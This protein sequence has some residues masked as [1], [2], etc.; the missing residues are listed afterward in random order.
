MLNDVQFLNDVK[1]LADVRKLNNVLPLNNVQG[2]RDV[3]PVS[4]VNSYTTP[5]VINMRPEK[6][7]SLLDVLLS[8]TQRDELLD[9]SNY[10]YNL[11][12][13]PVVNLLAGAAY[14][15][16]D[17]FI[18]PVVDNGLTNTQSYKEIGLNTLIELS[19]DLDIFSNLIKSQSSL[20]GGEF[21][22][23]RTF[24]D[25][26]GYSGER[27]V[28]NY[29]T[30]NFLSDVF[31]ETI[32]DPLTIAE[33]GAGAL[34]G[35]GR[36][37]AEA[38]VKTAVK[39]TSKEITEQAAR[40]IAEGT[41][42]SVAQYGDDVTYQTILKN[43]NRRTT[44]ELS[45]NVLKNATQSAVTTA[46]K[47]NGYRLF[48]SASMLKSGVEKFDSTLTNVIRYT[49]PAGLPA[50]LLH[51]GAKKLG[52]AIKNTIINS[53]NNVD[54]RIAFVKDAKYR[55][56]VG[57]EVYK[58]AALQQTL[59]KNEQI[60]FSYLGIDPTTF[61][62]DY[63]DFL[64][65]NNIDLSNADFKVFDYESNSALN[66]NSI[67]YRFLEY[68]LDKHI[69]TNGLDIA[70]INLL[71][72]KFSDGYWELVSLVPERFIKL[73]IAP[74]Q[75]Y[76]V[77][78]ELQSADAKSI[79]NSLENY[80]KTHADNLVSTYDYID[81]ELLKG[82]GLEN[83]EKYLTN[84]LSTRMLNKED[85]IKLS[86]LLESLGLSTDNFKEIK[87][88]LNSN[89]TDTEKNKALKDLIA[90]TNKNANI[91]TEKDYDKLYK[92]AKIRVDKNNRKQINKL[93][94]TNLTEAEY[95]PFKNMKQAIKSLKNNQEIEHALTYIEY[96]LKSQDFVDLETFVKESDLLLKNFDL[97][98]LEG[99]DLM[100]IAA[101][102]NI[103]QYV[104]K[105]KE[106]IEETDT[107]FNDLKTNPIKASSEIIDWYNNL[108]TVRKQLDRLRFATIKTGY[109]PAVQM[110]K[111][112]NKILDAIDVLLSDEFVEPACLY[113]N[114][115][116]NM[117]HKQLSKLGMFTQINQHVHMESDPV[118]RELLVQ[119]SNPKSILRTKT[120]PQFINV[121]QNSGLYE[122]ANNVYKVLSQ[123]DT[124]TH[125]NEL[126]NTKLPTTFKLETSTNDE[127]VHIVFDSIINHKQYSVS[128]ML[129]SKQIT[130]LTDP[131]QKELFDKIKISKVLNDDYL[132]PVSSTPYDRVLNEINSRIDKTALINKNFNAAEIAEIKSHCKNLLDVYLNKQKSIL[133][134]VP[135]MTLASLYSKDTIDMLDL[136][137][138]MRYSIGENPNVTA[139]ELN[140]FE[141]FQQ[142][143]KNFAKAIQ[144]GI[145]DIQKINSKIE[146]PLNKEMLAR[147]FRQVS[148]Q[149]NLY[150]AS[151]ASG[152]FTTN[153]YLKPSAKH[154][155]IND[156]F[157]CN[158]V[159]KQLLSDRIQTYADVLHEEYKYKQ[160]YLQKVKQA[161]IETYSRPHA[162][163]APINP[164][165]Y[166]NSLTE[167]QLLTWE[168]ITKGN[169][170]VRN[171]NTYYSV[172]DNLNKVQDANRINNSI[173]DQLG[174][175]ESLLTDSPIVSDSTIADIAI[176]ARN[177]EAIQYANR[178]IDA[179]LKRTLHSVDDLGAQRYKI[180][181]LIESD[182]K[183]ADSIIKAVVDIENINTLASESSFEIP[184][185]ADKSFNLYNLPDNA[186]YIKN[187]DDLDKLTKRT[188]GYELV[189]QN[190]Q[191]A[192]YAERKIGLARSINEWSAEEIAAHIQQQTPGGL[193]FYNNNIIRTINNDGSVTWSGFTNPFNFSKE[194][195]DKAGLKIKKVTVEGEGDWYYF[196]LTDTKQHKI[197]PQ[198]VEAH[199][200]YPEIQVKYNNIFRKY[201]IY[202]NAYDESNVPISYITAETL[203]KEAWENFIE[204]NQDF[205]GA[206][207]TQN[208][209]QKYSFIGS[210]NFFN[211]SYNRL[212][213]TVVGGYDAYH[214][215]NTRFSTDYIPN[216]FL[217]SRNTLSGMLSAVNRSNR[218]N[219]YITLF[220]NS[221]YELTNPLLE[222]MFSESSDQDIKDFF[223]K[224]QYKVAILKQD[225]HNLPVVKQFIVNNKHSLNTAKSLGA[226]MVPTATFGSMVKVVN[227]RQMTNNLL[228]IYKRVVPSTYKSMYLFTAGFPFRNG[229]DSLLFK[230]VNELGGLEALP[231][232]IRYEYQASK[233]MEL[234]NKIQE[235]ILYYTNGD[236]FNKEAIQHIL[237][238]H[239]LEEREV[240][241]LTD[242]FIQ[243]G[244][245]GGLSNSL[246]HWLET[247]NKT[248]T[249]D[250]RMLWERVYEDDILFAKLKRYPWDPSNVKAHPLNPLA[251]LRE[252]N[253][254]IEQTARFGLFLASVD[255]GMPIP[256]A[257]DR[258]IK[259]H[260]NYNSGDELIELCERIFWFSTFPVNNFNY[261]INGGLTKAPN[262]IRFAMDTQ[263]ASW[264]NGEYTYEELKKTNFLSYHALAGNIRIG[265]WIIKT[266][267]SLFDFLNIVTDLP[268]NLRSRLNPIVSV[269]IGAEEDPISELN[270]FITQWRNYQKFKEGN[271][272]PS[273]LS[274]I[275]EYDWTRTLGKWRSS[276][277][278]YPT[279]NKY[280]R[281]RKVPKYTK[282]V[283]KYYVRR[284]KTNVRKFSRVSLYKEPVNWYRIKRATY[285]DV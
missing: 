144:L 99:G 72:D 264:N 51:L 104:E 260:F 85:Y 53:L 135:N 75:I 209:Y 103:R 39:E 221:D 83:F 50:D 208:M 141:T 153:D 240:Y 218:I 280:P 44:K 235:E 26:L 74:T 270:P 180:D 193:V 204:A 93:Y 63:E 54:K 139:Q 111:T 29:D 102:D 89:L 113:I 259:T 117:T 197:K 281:I 8:K 129:L 40:D 84:L 172:W 200:A 70:A 170:S 136:T 66:N 150:S 219:K 134:I 143:F 127:L 24:L 145:D 106:F 234:H 94:N 275:N 35:A 100:Q 80:I 42:K 238:Q 91:L 155:H 283:R 201:G 126:L 161:L 77:F 227:N 79:A 250:I 266:S 88:I 2:L 20:A 38:A 165:T 205:F 225:R 49:T 244:A 95:T 58:N 107:L 97:R 16:Y 137:N 217:M 267:P 271:P 198:Y 243:S 121:L 248:N 159:E 262:L 255:G 249:D 285:F 60:Y 152:M 33:L 86:Q 147:R 236:T 10:F 247:Y 181:K 9:E 22:S 1:P 254:N 96:A 13:V 81:K 67:Q 18:K 116:D 34:K 199:Y 265:N 253:N 128:D 4:L 149:Y 175:I 186:L 109:A 132:N 59:Y 211:K 146:E 187:Q 47:S 171:R 56:A 206:E 119:L 131:A 41:L 258:V 273:V 166:F 177:T 78:K 188:Y 263:T 5:S 82:Y 168:T 151:I 190:S 37:T 245:S 11:K 118:T 212:N 203:N 251:H 230:N 73:T 28:Y 43:I 61:Q 31:F 142:E 237:S 12:D 279:W 269:A 164:N 220:F 173:N 202:L 108:N 231:D 194:E 130:D 32:S 183:T 189:K 252:L 17:A 69:P 158:N 98:E 195:L 268:G 178:P 64:F 120:V 163:F 48:M 25:A 7:N 213:I 282:A 256:D 226:I 110:R 27:A 90:H 154:Y 160:E 274:K 246:S 71:K 112:I 101:L 276:Y 148:E 6:A 14:H 55:K 176:T 133:D 182:I 105:T 196:A 157:N 179:H 19:E 233:A 87:A 277:K 30:G 162:L 21:G 167:Q 65:K 92:E 284:Y 232:V 15:G 223:N 125:L 46:L 257:I 174:F 45:E 242:I 278:K 140:L 115:V 224:G 123:I 241:Y 114:S 124:T 3:A 222:K 229:L 184:T 57:E 156:M 272:I 62:K 185:L 216:S 207:L 215:W 169:L 76:N 68:L 36:E 261:Y 214:L 210:N 228:D 191:M 138:K 122:Q 52:T 23:V 192:M 239:S